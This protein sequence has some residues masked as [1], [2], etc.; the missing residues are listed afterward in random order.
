LDPEA[1]HASAGCWEEIPTQLEANLLP[2]GRCAR[3]GD[4][5]RDGSLFLCWKG[6]FEDKSELCFRESTMLQTKPTYL[7]QLATTN[8]GSNA[9]PAAS[10]LQI[11]KELNDEYELKQGSKKKNKKNKKNTMEG[12]P[13]LQEQGKVLK[14]QQLPAGNCHLLTLQQ[15][16]LLVVKR[17]RRRLERKWRTR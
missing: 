1:S 3:L 5:V 14:S 13:A 15:L 16:P 10:L 8:C 7:K 12:S 2:H 17:L 9:T 11:S 6:M 4:F